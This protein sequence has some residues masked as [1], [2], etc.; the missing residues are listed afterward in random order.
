MFRALVVVNTHKG[1]GAFS[2]RRSVLSGKKE[3]H[4]LL[5]WLGLF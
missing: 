5:Y 4:F 2:R 3:R 1:N